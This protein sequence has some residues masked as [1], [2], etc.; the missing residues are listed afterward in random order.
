MTFTLLLDH[1]IVSDSEVIVVSLRLL[2]P[3]LVTET[4][5]DVE[6]LLWLL[7][8]LHSLFSHPHHCAV[9]IQLIYPNN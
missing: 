3:D 9:H 5:E 2:A 1:F 4:L 6:I 7:H 8:H